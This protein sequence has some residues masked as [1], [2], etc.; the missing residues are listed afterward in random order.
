[1][2]EQW[3]KPEKSREISSCTKTAPPREDF[4]V[5]QLAQFLPQAA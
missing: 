5:E 2:R 1:M 3:P 4:L